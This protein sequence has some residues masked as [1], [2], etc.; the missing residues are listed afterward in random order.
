MYQQQKLYLSYPHFISIREPKTVT[1]SNTGIHQKYTSFLSLKNENM[2]P[3][4]SFWCLPSQLFSIVW[5]V[6][7]RLLLVDHENC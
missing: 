4:S 2:Y 7:R 3:V 1:T 6:I 5:N